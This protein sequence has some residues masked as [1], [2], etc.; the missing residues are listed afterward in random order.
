MGRGVT[1]FAAASVIAAIVSVGYASGS[2]GGFAG[3][4]GDVLVPA[5]KPKP[6]WERP[7]ARRRRDAGTPMPFRRRVDAE[8]KNAPRA[9]A[10]APPFERVLRARAAAQAKRRAEFEERLN[11]PVQHETHRATEPFGEQ[12]DVDSARPAV[13]ERSD[14]LRHVRKKQAKRERRDARPFE[15]R[16]RGGG[17]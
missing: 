16:S 5:E 6:K 13:R 15:K 8:G 4:V 10:S 2:V 17:K 1:T 12:V 3:A 7:P 9:P 14:F 11:G